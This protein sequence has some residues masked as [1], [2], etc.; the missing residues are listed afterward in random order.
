MIEATHNQSQTV[1][2]HQHDQHLP[3]NETTVESQTHYTLTSTLN[4]GTLMI[5]L[6]HFDL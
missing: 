6:K 1:N 4:N 5:E 3:E 2:H